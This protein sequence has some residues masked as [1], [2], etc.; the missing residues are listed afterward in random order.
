MRKRSSIIALSIGL[1]LGLLLLMGIALT[2]R[3]TRSPYDRLG[4]TGIGNNRMGD[5]GIGNQ[6]E[7][8]DR[9]NLINTPNERAP[10]PA[11]PNP[12]LEQPINTP[13]NMGNGRQGLNN[14]AA[15]L[16]ETPNS[17]IADNTVNHRQKAARIK[18]A[19]LELKEVE[20]A[21][22]IVTGNTALIAYKTND[23]TRDANANKK[24][25]SDKAKAVE[26][27]VTRI[28]VTESVADYNQVGKLL[29][30]IANNKPA[31][32]VRTEVDRMLQRITP[33]FR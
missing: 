6:G 12:G 24:V 23:V 15:R 21:N 18:G 4:N 2:P 13:G 9:N 20:D 17:T 1:S 11:V 22:V 31:T 29:T 26:P 28:V 19:L 7:N 30:D 16:N 25:I 14:D 27:S 5:T 32:Q 33:A 10:L 3:A 8:L